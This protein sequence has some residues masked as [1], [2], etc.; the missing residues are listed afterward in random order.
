MA[1]PTVEAMVAVAVATAPQMATPTV[2]AMAAV[3]VVMV[4]LPVV[5]TRCPTS[6]RA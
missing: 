1:T 3:V 4:A 2:E 6:A 5:V